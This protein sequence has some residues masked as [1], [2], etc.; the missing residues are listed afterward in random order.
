MDW[1]DSFTQ[2]IFHYTNGQTESFNV[3]WQGDDSMTP[4][5]TQQKLSQFLDKHWCILHLPEQ[6]VCINTA[7]ILKVEMKPPLR[8]VKGQG[9]FSDVRRVTA[10][11]CSSEWS[12]RGVTGMKSDV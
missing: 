6:T 3:L 5:D 8:E 10:L 4:Q 2:I 9:V 12:K 11:N 7:N 1:Q